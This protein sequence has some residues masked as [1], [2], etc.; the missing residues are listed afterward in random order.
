[1]LLCTIYIYSGGEEKQGGFLIAQLGWAFLKEIS[2]LCGVFSA[3][4]KISCKP[5]MT[6]Y[7]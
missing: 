4:A 6:N 2:S 7:Q 3:K 1:L 5:L